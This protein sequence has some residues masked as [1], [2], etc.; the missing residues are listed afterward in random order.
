MAKLAGPQESW[1]LPQPHAPPFLFSLDSRLT[2]FSGRAL[3]LGARTCK[4][5]LWVQSWAARVITPS[6]LHHLLHYC[7]RALTSETSWLPCLI[8]PVFTGMAKS[9]TPGGKETTEENILMWGLL[10]VLYIY[11]AL[12][13]WDRG[14]FR[15]Q[16]AHPQQKVWTIFRAHL[17]RKERNFTMF[18]KLIETATY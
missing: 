15:A 18:Q 7:G 4:R 12:G 6:E 13:K 1:A 8:R 17:G 16:I 14:S 2:R 3:T 10:P 9:H 5:P 11:I